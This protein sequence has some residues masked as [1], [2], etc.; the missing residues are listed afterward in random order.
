MYVYICIYIT[1]LII[2]YTEVNKLD[3]VPALIIH[4][5]IEKID[6]ELVLH[7]HRTFNI[8]F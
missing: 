1:S 4:S 5:Q 2:A 8:H 6:C 7:T 3:I